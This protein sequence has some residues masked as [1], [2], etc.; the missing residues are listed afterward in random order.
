[1]A[2][3][4]HTTAGQAVGMTQKIIQK[5]PNQEKAGALA[6]R[7]QSRRPNDEPR[8]S[9]IHPAYERVRSGVLRLR[10]RSLSVLCLSPPR[11]STA[12]LRRPWPREWTIRSE[13]A[14][15]TIQ[16]V[17]HDWHHH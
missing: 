9:K 14:E 10:G 8:T 1:M 15:E 6:S 11:N 2:P 12:E 17:S 3:W 13:G 7:M 16:V 5:L 4:K